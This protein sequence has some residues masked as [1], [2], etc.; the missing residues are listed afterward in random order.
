MKEPDYDF[1]RQERERL[2]DLP[3]WQPEIGNFQ[4]AVDVILETEE[5]ISFLRGN[6]MTDHAVIWL[7]PWCDLCE[8]KAG[9]GGRNWCEDD[10]WGK[11]NECGNKP[12]RY[13]RRQNH[14]AKARDRIAEKRVPA[15]DQR[16][17]ND[18]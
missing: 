12:V 16:E 2:L 5:L 15:P 17:K 13:A 8:A 3:L 14:G 4:A 6:A 9:T 10:V 7:Q 18:A 11:C 1:W